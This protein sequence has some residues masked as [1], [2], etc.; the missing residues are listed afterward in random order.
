MQEGTSEEGLKT[1]G[2]P[3]PIALYQVACA[4]YEVQ[5]NIFFQVAL[6][7][8]DP[9]QKYWDRI[10]QTFVD[11]LLE[12]GEEVV[13]FYFCN[14]VPA[15]CIYTR[16][17][18]SEANGRKGTA[19]PRGHRTGGNGRGTGGRLSRGAAI[20]P[21]KLYLHVPTGSISP[22]WIV[23]DLM[24][25]GSLQTQT[26]EVLEGGRSSA[27]CTETLFDIAVALLQKAN[28]YEEAFHA[29]TRQYLEAK[30]EDGVQLTQFE[31]LEASNQVLERVRVR[32]ANDPLRAIASE[33]LS[34]A[35]ETYRRL[36]EQNAQRH[37]IFGMLL[38]FAAIIVAV[39]LVAILLTL[40]PVDRTLTNM[41]GNFVAA[42]PQA[43]SQ[44]VIAI[45]GLV[46]ISLIF[47]GLGAVVSVM[48]RIT[49]GTLSLSIF[50][51]QQTLRRAGVFRPIVGAV[52]ASVILM[53]LQ[54]GLLAIGGAPPE[55]ERL[56]Y[57]FAVIAF[58]AGFS[59]RW[60]QDMLAT[61]GIPPRDAATTRS[62]LDE[63]TRFPTEVVSGWDVWR[64][65]V[66]AG[67]STAPKQSLNT[68]DTADKGV[69]STS[70][71]TR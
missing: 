69:A 50:A 42:A 46:N 45:I 31:R 28:A 29:E 18:S 61:A 38:G 64:P 63:P 27:I 19:S 1:G 23:R 5:Q 54:T 36:A 62:A 2:P 8:G 66:P 11:Q 48:Q 20:G 67:A 32:A 30:Q 49:A 57:F 56:W 68:G 10:W 41:V 33:Q 9:P 44:A 60:A 40:E 39:S 22:D 3:G 37:Y 17:I 43:T 58:F 7:A 15:G 13:D 71:S 34:S 51:G 14:A 70:T 24:R 47:G 59:E 4:Y 65:P 55:G 16:Q 53:L 21:E 35:Q 25:C 6:M 52:L 26:R 12:N